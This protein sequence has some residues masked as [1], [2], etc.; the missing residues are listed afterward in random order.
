M[1]MKKEQRQIAEVL[2]EIGMSNE[3][4]ELITNL[5]SEDLKLLLKVNDK[6]KGHYWLNQR[7]PFYFLR[8][9]PYI[10]IIP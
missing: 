3:L 10:L 4:I 2:M 9:V 6:E 1:H 8:N 7:C 5:S